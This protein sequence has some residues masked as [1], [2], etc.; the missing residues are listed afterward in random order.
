[1]DLVIAL[2]VGGITGWVASLVRGTDS[3]MGVQPPI[4]PVAAVLAN[5]LAGVVGSVPGLWLAGVFGLTV[6]RG[7]GRWLV[8]LAGAILLIGIVRA[9]ERMRRRVT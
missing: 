1:M 7:P 6:W 2:V 8:S 9:L 5:I 3:R 4:P